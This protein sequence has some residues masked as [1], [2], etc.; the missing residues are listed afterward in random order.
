MRLSADIV[1]KFQAHILDW[2]RENG[3][4]T[5]PWRITRNPYRIL[6][7]ECMLQQTQVD[8]VLPKY[9]EF[10]RLFPNP[11]R[12]A[13][14]RVED[15]LHTW[16]GLGYNR[17]ALYLHRAAKTIRAQFKGIFPREISDMESLPGVGPYTAR[18]VAAFAFGAATP[19]IET[20]IRRVYLHFFFP[21]Q[22]AVADTEILP[23]VEQ[24]LYR[25]DVHRWY[26]ALMDYGALALSGIPNPNRRSRHYTRQSRFEGSRRYARAKIVEYVLQKKKAA[27]HDLRTYFSLD[28]HLAEYLETDVLNGILDD[29]V[30]EGFLKNQKGVVRIA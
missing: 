28:P 19:F 22:T 5:L 3:R 9:R 30:R 20:N 4:H 7:S 10:M 17:R 26:S 2:H 23:L 25:E 21:G 18:A 24:T 16:R 8:R 11:A 13:E 12:L 29:L 6:I 27:L 14:A 15:V 1:R